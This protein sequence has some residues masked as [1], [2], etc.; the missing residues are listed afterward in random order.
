LTYTTAHMFKDPNDFFEIQALW[1]SWMGS[2]G[3]TDTLSSAT[4]VNSTDNTITASTA[5]M[6]YS[7]SAG[8]HTVWLA[9]GT[10][11][12]TNEFTSRIT[13]SSSRVKDFTIKVTVKER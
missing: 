1:T 6:S 8:T 7:T 3:S 12:S 4:W 2:D 11:G 10:A 13:T 5:L 9:G